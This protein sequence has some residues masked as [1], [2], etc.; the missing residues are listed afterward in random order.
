MELFDVA[1][2]AASIYEMLFFNVKSVLEY[3]TLS[4]LKEGNELMYNRWTVISDDRFANSVS[5]RE[6]IYKENAI[7][8]PEFSKIVTISF[9]TIAL[10]NGN[11]KRS[12]KKI[13]NNNEAVIIEEFMNVLHQE[14]FE[15]KNSTPEK[16][17][18]LCGHN[19]SSFEIPLLIKRFLIHYEKFENKTLPYI[20]KKQLSSKPWESNVVDVNNIWKFNG[21]G[22]TSLPLFSDFLNLKRKVELLNPNDLSDYYWDNIELNQEET[23]D[24]ISLQSLTQ[25]NFIVQFINIIRKL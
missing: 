22:S 2:K 21:N 3:P 20:L 25:I 9:G 14:S 7:N 6:S 10:E 18:I 5:S 15:G 24:Y 17:R 23:L 8:Y 12:F 4:K 1:F 11:I 13:N 16:Y 19:I